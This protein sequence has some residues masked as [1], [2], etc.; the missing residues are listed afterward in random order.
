MFTTSQ[1]L[2]T[3]AR[4][5]RYLSSL[6]VFHHPVQ[7]KVSKHSQRHTR[8]DKVRSR[9]QATHFQVDMA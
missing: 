5:K 3:T 2:H 6:I 4:I 8:P 1:L 7:G 9:I